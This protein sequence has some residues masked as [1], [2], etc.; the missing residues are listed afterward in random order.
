M[1]RFDAYEIKKMVLRDLLPGLYDFKELEFAPYHTN[2]RFDAIGIR[3]FN[4]TSRIIEVK[5]CRADF[6]SDHKWK[7][8][9]PF[10]TQFYFA[11]PPGAIKLEELPPEIGLAEVNTFSNGYSAL[12]YVKKCKRLPLLTEESYIKL[13]EG[14]F[15]GRAGRG[16]R[17]WQRL[18]V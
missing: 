8:Y 13:L 9:L 16:G 3:R 15:G 12:R 17:T 1:D 10:A 5:S 11:A 14:A 6:L 2:I 7:T 4:R 18:S